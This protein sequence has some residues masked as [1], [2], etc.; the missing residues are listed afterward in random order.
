MS[1]KFLYPRRFGEVFQMAEDFPG[2]LAQQEACRLALVWPYR[3]PQHQLSRKIDRRVNSLGRS[4]VV[5]AFVD[6]APWLGRGY[7]NAI[8]LSDLL[9]PA[10]L[11]P[12]LRH[13][14]G[15]TYDQLDLLTQE[16]KVWFM[17]RHSPEDRDW[18]NFAE[19]WAD[20]FRDWLTDPYDLELTA[21][22]LRP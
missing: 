13:E 10:Y 8:L 16:D 22:L 1:D 2:T 12:I 14:L 7:A 20:T 17:A 11:E 19:A 18:R 21:R 3:S 6:I 4:Y 9:H 5:L 15:H